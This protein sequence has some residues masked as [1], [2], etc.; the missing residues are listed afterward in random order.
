MFQLLCLL[1]YAGS[2][3]DAYMSES[4]RGEASLFNFK[5]SRARHWVLHFFFQ[6]LKLQEGRRKV[7]GWPDSETQACHSSC[8]GTSCRVQEHQMSRY[9]K[10]DVTDP[11]RDVAGKSQLTRFFFFF[12]INFDFAY[13][14]RINTERDHTSKASILINLY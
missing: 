9:Q 12:L 7:G 2:W 10:V 6:V 4:K 14:T 1:K 11:R 13:K 8:S 5:T 3:K